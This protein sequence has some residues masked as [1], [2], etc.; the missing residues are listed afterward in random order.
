MQYDR[1]PGS[2]AGI[3]T[4]PDTLRSGIKVLGS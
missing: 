4:C 2:R 1:R 3:F